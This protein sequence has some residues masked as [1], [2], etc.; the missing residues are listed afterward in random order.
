MRIN[1]GLEA[2]NDRLVQIWASRQRSYVSGKPAQC[3]HHYYSRHNRLLRW[4]L[5]NIVPLT[6]EEHTQLHSGKL[7][8]KVK[9]PC[10]EL[11]LERM[12]HKDYKNYLLENNLTDAEF[13]SKCNKKLKEALS[14]EDTENI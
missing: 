8:Y 9:N 11:Y 14:A 2:Q 4:D 7:E 1:G 6:L 12:Y 13:V 3:G 10:N 5:K